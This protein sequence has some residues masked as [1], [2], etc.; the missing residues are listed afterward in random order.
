MH[1]V[2]FDVIYYTGRRGK[3][4]LREL[5][6]S[7]FDVKIGSD[8]KEY[9]QINFNEK[10]KKN[11]GNETSTT[12]NSLH[13]NRHIISAMDTPLCPVKSIKT[14]MSLLNEKLSAFFQYPSNDKQGYSI[15]CVGKNSLGSMM[16]EI[17]KKAELSRVYTNHQIRKTTA[18]AMYRSGFGLKEISHVTKHKNLDSL[19]H[20]VD[21]PTHSDKHQYNDALYKYAQKS[22]AA[23]KRKMPTNIND[24]N[25][26][27]SPK[28][29]K[30]PE[31]NASVILYQES[32]DMDTVP[33]KST[34]NVANN[35]LRQAS[36]MFQN[37]NFS[38]CQFTFTLPK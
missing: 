27:P 3:E 16:S 28:I 5:T 33:V 20:Y 6:K 35:Q 34:Q 7:S 21:G 8:G 36:H 9:V 24:K 37:A 10:M 15:K 12:A 19:K 29:A 14:Y 11:Q 13:N 26:V 38:N 30:E 31:V 23:S 32:Q 22:P 2:F 18:T 25:S 4:G 17:S 1:K